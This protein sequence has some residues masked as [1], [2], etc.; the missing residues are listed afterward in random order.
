MPPKPKYSDEE[1]IEFIERGLPDDEIIGRLKLSTAARYTYRNRLKELR[2]L[3]DN[4]KPTIKSTG[5]KIKHDVNYGKNTAAKLA[6]SVK[7]DVTGFMAELAEKEAQKKRIEKAKVD[8]FT[9]LEKPN[10]EELFEQEVQEESKMIQNDKGPRNKLT[11]L[12]DHLFAEMERL[13]D[14]D[15]KGEALI[16]EIGRS[17]AIADIATKIVDNAALVLKAA[18]MTANAMDANYKVPK[19]IGLDT[20]SDPIS[21]NGQPVKSAAARA[22]IASKISGSGK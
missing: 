6:K 18:S 7:V 5:E 12:N 9:W 14:E 17:K 10:T 16:E 21:I 4:E 2:E 11:D 19:M 3:R 8:N 15:L 13:G 20:G 1:L 22:Q